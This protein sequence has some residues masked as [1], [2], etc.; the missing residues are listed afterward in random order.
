MKHKLES[1]LVGKI[2]I[3]SD[4][5]MF[6]LMSV[7]SVMPSNHLILCCPLLL[8]PSIFPSIRVSSNES[9]LCIRW[10]KCWSFVISPS[11]EYSGLIPLGLTGWISLLSK[12]LSRAF[13]STMVQKHQFFG[14]QPSLW[15][16]SY[17]CTWLLEKNHSL[18]YMELC[19]VP[20]QKFG[21]SGFLVFLWAECLHYHFVCTVHQQCVFCK[22]TN[23]ENL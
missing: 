3:T 19:F 5:Q 4:M 8:S 12:G 18:D 10:P 2:S 6:K 14:T 11:I 20:C 21:S 22:E 9:V 23:Q 7:E 15:S 1:R 16:S 17:I 13:S